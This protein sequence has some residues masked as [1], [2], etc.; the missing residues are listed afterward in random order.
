MVAM[1]LY[2]QE[3]QLG[4]ALF[5]VGPRLGWVYGDLQEQ[6]SS[7]LHS[8]LLIEREHRAL[9]ALEQAH[10]ELEQRVALR[11]A[12]L[13]IANE[14]LARLAEE[15]AA[16]R[17]VA[18]LVARQSSPEEVLRAVAE[19]VAELL[20]TDGVGI[21]RFE[22][23]GT[24]T[25]VARSDTPWEPVPLGTRFPLEGE[26]VVA[27]VLRTG[28]TARLDDW[29]NASGRVAERAR[30]LGIRCSVATPIVVAG[31]L[32]GTMVAVTAQVEPLPADTESRFTEFTELVATA[33]SNAQV[34]TELAASRARLAAAADDERRRVVRDLHDGAQQR[35][36]HTVITIKLA[37]R[38]LD[39]GD[40]ARPL[41]AEALAQA[42]EANVELREL[43]HGI[44]PAVLASGGL[45]AVVEALASRTP[46]PIDTAVSVGRFPAAI[47]AT[48]YFVVA[49]ALTNVAK[50]ARAKRA[51]V[52]AHVEEGGLRVEV[53][54][55]GVGGA[56]SDG[57]GLV[58]L[59]DRIAALD[60][61]FQVE[62]PAGGGTLVT[63]YIPLP[64]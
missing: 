29:A 36:V 15:Q 32:W 51:Q 58:G 63:A 28:K 4:F 44:L 12:E 60:G 7:A 62:S 6:L 57:S 39:S 38:A 40:D 26:S 11:T 14:A 27:S 5:E 48:A 10:G 19:E 61:R 43:V 21:F 22:P 1:P 53:R 55:D 34:R 30:S 45:R 52:S 18:T 47:E 3:R 16:L 33:I 49:E 56:R 23:D 42:E 17:R 50:H 46:V 59:G 9:A 35:L 37:R 2:F 20:G 24:A 64:E 8:A 25:Q 13:A 54:D 41:L 31:R